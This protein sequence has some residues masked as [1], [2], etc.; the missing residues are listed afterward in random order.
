MSHHAL[1]RL[2]RP[3]SPEPT[4]RLLAFQ[5][6]QHWFC[7]PLAMARRVLPRPP[8]AE[9]R[10]V[11]LIQL[12][13]DYIPVVDI[14]PLV[15]GGTPNPATTALP[16][17]V[18]APTVANPAV[19]QHSLVVIDLSQGDAVAL[20][21]DGTPALK[22]VRQAAFSPVPPIYQSLHQLRGLSSVIRPDSN[23]PDTSALPMFLLNVEALIPPKEHLIQTG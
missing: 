14:A 21:V 22:R 18:T 15:Y 1:V 8:T 11:E 10:A 2:R 9:G 4:L 6:R 13:Q 16:A 17:P 19:P 20:L 5:L 7:V 12:Q 23:P 3:R